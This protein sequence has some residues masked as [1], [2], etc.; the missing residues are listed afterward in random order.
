ML[1]LNELFNQIRDLY[2]KASDYEQAFVAAKLEETVNAL[3]E[4][5]YE[6]W[7]ACED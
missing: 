7:N 6:S 2:A 5:N 3:K 1:E 4:R